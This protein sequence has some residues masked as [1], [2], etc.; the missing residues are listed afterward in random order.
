M[1][2]AAP[3]LQFLPDEPLGLVLKALPVDARGRAA[4]VCRAW[5]DLLADP[6][7]WAVLDL[8]ALS[9][10]AGVPSHERINTMTRAVS[11]RARGQLRV[12]HVA[13]PVWFHVEPTLLE[14]ARANSGSLREVYFAPG[15]TTTP[16]DVDAL[17]EAAP[18]LETLVVTH[19]SCDLDDAT[20]LLRAAP[21]LAA[22]QLHAISVEAHT[23]EPDEMDD[24]LK[25]LAD[26]S[27]HPTL[28]R[29]ELSYV[30]LEDGEDA[31][32]LVNAILQRPLLRALT[33]GFDT[34]AP[35]GR[36]LAR[37]LTGGALTELSFEFLCRE[38]DSL[39]CSAADAKLFADAL[40]ANTTLTS[41]TISHSS[42]CSNVDSARTV[43]RALVGHRSLRS[44]TLSGDAP[45]E[46]K[47]DRKKS[48]GR[49][50]G[51]IVAADSPTLTALDLSG[52]G[53]QV[54]DQVFFHD[55]D[56]ARLMD[57]LYHNHHLRK[58]DISDSRTTDIFEREEVLPAV[59]ACTSL[60]ELKMT[61]KPSAADE[62]MKLVSCR[63][64]RG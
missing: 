4:C 31:A 50:L 25:A 20:R 37:L 13:K 7:W 30:G 51:K 3:T 45:H 15:D 34:S 61:V 8:V 2:A 62:A 40:R 19:I 53:G 27:L 56:L 11:A 9:T 39:C 24:F 16:K 63:A 10:R 57:A 52:P 48:L 60:R 12:L 42:L 29:L 49:V 21:P 46:L 38:S 18:L 1:R 41:L 54:F 6:A 44:L 35:S 17:V 47:Y 22:L 59:R 23:M 33:F 26:P 14:L 5:R 32:T 43:L 28:S 36:Q 64:W 55:G 58:L